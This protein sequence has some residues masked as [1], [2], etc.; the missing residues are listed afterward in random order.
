MTRMFALL[1][2]IWMCELF[3]VSER[4]T[5]MARQHNQFG[6]HVIYARVSTRDQRDNSESLD[7]QIQHCLALM[8][9][10]G[11][12]KEYKPIQEDASGYTI[13]REMLNGLRK[14]IRDGRIA[15][16]ILNES[17]RL[18]REIKH[19]EE[20][21]DEMYDNGVK[22]YIYYPHMREM[23]LHPDS[24]DREMLLQEMM[25]NRKWGKMLKQQMEWGKQAKL[26]RGKF[27]GYSA[28]YGYTMIGKRDDKHLEIHA[29]HSKVVQDIFSWYISGITITEI[30]KMLRG[31]P[32]PGESKGFFR[33]RNSGEWSLAT[34]YFILNNAYTYAGTM[35]QSYKGKTY[36]IEVP[37]LISVSTAK[38]AI[39]KLEVGSIQSRRNKKHDYL[40]S[41]N[42]TCQCGYKATG[43]SVSSRGKF[44]TYYTCTSMTADKAKGK[45]GM[46]KCRS[47]LIDSIIWEFAKSFIREPK[48]LM[49]TFSEQRELIVKQNEAVY[50]RLS[51]LNKTIENNTRKLQQAID[52]LNSAHSARVKGMIQAEIERLDSLLNELEAEKIGVE[53]KIQDTGYSD[54]VLT[55]IEHFSHA[56][57]DELEYFDFQRRKEAIEILGITATLAHEKGMHVVYI[58]LCLHTERFTVGKEDD[59]SAASNHSSTFVGKTQR[60]FRM[61]FRFEIK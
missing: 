34:L 45:C 37:A 26:S 5:T 12:P 51:Q 57:K 35:V 52:N 59:V 39:D 22:L 31:I 21:L 7:T 48:A 30:L 19:G 8:D 29:E 17:S 15:S 4:E 14:A 36:T 6:A 25:F 32:T 2:V 23:D 46:K 1:M 20:L 16:I 42:I 9:K 53:Q 33:S 50:K 60:T 43:T 54:E 56:V 61:T 40:L 44:Y 28:P 47:E 55:A 27:I 11:L 24:I 18:S 13:D 10:H 58:H 41:H 38:K 3:L 49:A